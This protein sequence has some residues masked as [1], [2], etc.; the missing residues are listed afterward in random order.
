M[1]LSS[2][3]HLA[4]CGALVDCHSCGKGVT[5][6]QWVEAGDAVKRPIVHK[7]AP[8]Q[9]II[10][11]TMLVMLSLKNSL[12]T[13]LG[14]TETDSLAVDPFSLLPSLYFLSLCVC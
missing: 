6:N 4:T 5:G 2:R 7:S 8:Q 14:T 10:Q 3:E 11:S 1:I 13:I 12:L 9:R